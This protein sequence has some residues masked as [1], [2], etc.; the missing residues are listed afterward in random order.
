VPKLTLKISCPGCKNIIQASVTNHSNFLIFICP[1]CHK[2]VACYDNKI[3]IISDKLVRKLISKKHLQYCG[4]I[5]VNNPTPQLCP[6]KGLTV[7]FF[8]DLK[9]LLE[10]SQDVND[11]ISKI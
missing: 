2:N 4:V 6:D 3:D 7:D 8:T 5:E 10:T 1:K 11:F 9:I